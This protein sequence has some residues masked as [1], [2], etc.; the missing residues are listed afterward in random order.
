M[1]VSGRRISLGSFDD[2]CRALAIARK[3]LI[4]ARSPVRRLD[5]LGKVLGH[6]SLWVKMDSRL[7]DGGSK[8]R[9]IEF[10]F[11][12][13]EKRGAKKL[14]VT[15]LLE[16]NFARIAA[17]CGIALGFQMVLRLVAAGDVP[18]N[19]VR[20]VTERLRASG[21]VVKLVSAREYRWRERDAKGLGLQVGFSR[22]VMAIPVGGSSPSGTIGYIRAAVELSDQILE[23]Q[24]PEPNEVFAP[25]G[26]GGLLAGLG[27]GF[28]LLGGR[29]R[30]I[31]GVG[32]CA[33]TATQRDVELLANSALRTLQGGSEARLR[34]SPL[35]VSIT[36]AFYEAG[37]GISTPSL[38]TANDLLAATEGIRVDETYASKALLA[39]LRRAKE[40]AVRGKALLLWLTR[41]SC[42]VPE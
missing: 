37:Y 40:P 16:S 25:V 31:T 12:D 1:F 13:A 4:E 17:T 5:E 23:G 26:S 42:S 9:S 8:R 21:A 29:T 33:G 41:E 22:D 3:E 2:G 6:N 36:S 15:G 14:L 24:C 35:A 38:R 19:R 20:Q 7:G 34:L 18:R 11:G 27:A 32:V 30:L 10:I 28:T 39:F